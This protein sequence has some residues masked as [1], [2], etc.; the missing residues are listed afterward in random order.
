MAM[1]GIVILE[2]GLGREALK[3]HCRRL[4]LRVRDFERLVE[5]ELEQVGKLRKRGLWDRFD[6]ILDDVLEPNAGED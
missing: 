1:K 5:A 2:S 4:K 3:K 6:E